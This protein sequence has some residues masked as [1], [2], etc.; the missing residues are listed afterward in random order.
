MSKLLVDALRHT[1]ASSDGVTLDSSGNVTFAG[2]ATCSGTATGFGVGGKLLQVVSV[3][4]TDVASFTASTG[5]WSDIT[6]LTASITPSATGSK[7]LVHYKTSYSGGSGQRG[8]FR[9]VRDSTVIGQGDQTQS[10]INRASFGSIKSGGTS[11]THN[12]S[13]MYLDSPSTT[14]STT[15]KIQGSAEDAAGTVYINVDAGQTNGT[16]YYTGASH[17]TLMEIGA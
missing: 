13:T 6:G 12:V 17:I 7:I 9:L 3:N 1:G 4:K 8:S 14:S 2:N 11:R 5:N 16:A 10:S 15:Y